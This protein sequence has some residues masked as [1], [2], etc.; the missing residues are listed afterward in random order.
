MAVAPRQQRDRDA[1][2]D[3]DRGDSQH[4][5][6]LCPSMNGC[7]RGHGEDPVNARLGAQPL[8]HVQVFAP[9]PNG[10]GRAPPPVARMLELTTR[11]GSRSW[12]ANTPRIMVCSRAVSISG[13]HR[14]CPQT[15]R[16]RTHLRQPVDSAFR[17]GE[18]EDLG[19]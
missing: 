7:G 13:G 19:E 5:I 17:E 16:V 15:Y 10:P 11:H 9:R 6:A 18:S 3:R 4:R 1:G 2:D 12:V 8:R 14:G